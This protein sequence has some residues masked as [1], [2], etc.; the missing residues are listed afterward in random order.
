M[1]DVRKKRTQSYLA[2]GMFSALLTSQLYGRGQETEELQD[3]ISGNTAA[4]IKFLILR[5]LRKN[6]NMT[7]FR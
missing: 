3:R 7:F 6:L 4:L 2:D 1:Q 5:K